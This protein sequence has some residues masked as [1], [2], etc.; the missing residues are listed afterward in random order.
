MIHT[1]SV[2]AHLIPVNL[3][4]EQ[5]NIIYASEADILNVAL[6]GMTAKEWKLSNQCKE[7]NI[8]DYATTIELAILSNLEFFNSK[9][10]EQKITQKER[11]NILNEEANKEKL[12]F[13][14]NQNKSIDYTKKVKKITN[15]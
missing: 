5:K 3:T 8:R 15:E 9:L 4:N 7:G 6:F 2:K 14:Q 11:L 13:N 12:L 1:D 10:I